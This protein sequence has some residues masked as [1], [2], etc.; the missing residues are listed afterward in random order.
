MEPSAAFVDVLFSPEP[1]IWVQRMLGPGLADGFRAI[2]ELGTTWGVLL[3]AA[4]AFWVWGR[5]DLYA[6]LGVLVLEVAASLLMNQ[7]FG[8]ERPS[9]PRIV[10]HESIPVSS[11]PSGHVL[12]ATVLWGVLYLRKR[13][14]ASLLAAVVLAV[15]LSRL[16][17]GVHYLTDVAGGALAGLLVLWAYG[18]A[19]SWF[20]EKA[21]RWP[22]RVWILLASVPIVGVSIAGWTGFLGSNPFK[23][24]AAA[25]AVATGASLLVEHRA[26]GFSPRPAARAPWAWIAA[27]LAVLAGV[28]LLDRAVV[29]AGL[30]AGAALLATGTVWTMLVVPALLARSG[31]RTSAPGREAATAPGSSRHGGGGP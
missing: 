18:P 29:G 25:L 5:R 22:E 27:G 28:A 21:A 16:Y 23:W 11:F 12:L 3:V 31:A 19:W 30:W 2:S 14:R 10:K 9:D 26:V 8:V 24:H 1:T 15:S 17:L 4:L 20:A 13:I 7:L 6:L